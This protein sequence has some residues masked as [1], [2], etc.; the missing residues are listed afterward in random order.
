MK[1]EIIAITQCNKIKLIKID[2][3]R[4][5]VFEH[6]LKSLALQQLGIMTANMLTES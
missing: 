5:C 6:G 2:K 3:K 4:S 1:L